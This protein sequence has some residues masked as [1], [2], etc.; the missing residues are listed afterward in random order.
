MDYY[1]YYYYYQ[2]A[3]ILWLFHCLSVCCFCSYENP[4]YGYYA[5]KSERCAV[6]ASSADSHSSAGEPNTVGTP[7]LS[8]H[9]SLTTSGDDQ[10][11]LLGRRICQGARS[12]LFHFYVI[13]F[14]LILLVNI[15]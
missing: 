14:A 7:M 10:S 4:D 1:D 6:P 5:A 15:C 8:V 13:F 12:L 9:S 11:T 3:V 2:A